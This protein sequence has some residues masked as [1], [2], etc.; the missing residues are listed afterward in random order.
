L[1]A[2]ACGV[3]LYNNFGE[4]GSILITLLLLN[5]KKWRNYCKT[6]HLVLKSVAA[7]PW[8]FDY[9]TAGYNFIAYRE[10]VVQLRQR[11]I[12]GRGRGKF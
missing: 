7:L 2:I 11:S 3:F 6:Y 8:E 10:I 5:E 12:G 4:R 1:L 9:S